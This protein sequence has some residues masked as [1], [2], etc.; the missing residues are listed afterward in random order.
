MAFGENAAVGIGERDSERAAV[1][2]LERQVACDEPT[3]VRDRRGA[4]LPFDAVDPGH[5]QP[6]RRHAL[7]AADY[8]T[9]GLKMLIAPTHAAHAGAFFDELQEVIGHQDRV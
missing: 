2:E 4:D 7:K 6:R 5:G 9:H 1:F 3:G 8:V